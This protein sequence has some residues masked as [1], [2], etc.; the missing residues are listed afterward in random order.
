MGPREQ[1]YYLALGVAVARKEENQTLGTFIDRHGIETV[2]DALQ[3]TLTRLD[4]RTT[5]RSMARALDLPVV[6][7]ETI[8]QAFI[9]ILSDLDQSPIDSQLLDMPLDGIENE[10]E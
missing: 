7:T 8:F 4:G 2:A 10:T 9:G 3:Y 1:T 6:E 5:L